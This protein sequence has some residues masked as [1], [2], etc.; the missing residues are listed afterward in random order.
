MP[1]KPSFAGPLPR[2]PVWE[3]FRDTVARLTFQG[4]TVGYLAF[5]VTHSARQVGGWLWWRRW[6]APVEHLEW[7]QTMV[8]IEPA[9]RATIDGGLIADPANPWLMAVR[10]GSVD[11]FR[12]HLASR[13]YTVE[14]LT[15]HERELAWQEYGFA[16]RSPGRETRT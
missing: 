5:H 11:D 4:R 14:W 10:D 13:R 1:W 15:G 12:P 9:A 16:N 3:P 2:D 7:M 6:A 8:D